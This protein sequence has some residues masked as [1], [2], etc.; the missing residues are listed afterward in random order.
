MKNNDVERVHRILAGDDTAFA[1]LVEKYENQV[2]ALAWR[3]TGDFHIAEEI[4]K[5]SQIVSKPVNFEKFDFPF[6]LTSS[7]NHAPFVT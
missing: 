1:S 4:S 7:P 3:K 5:I 6:H 2:H